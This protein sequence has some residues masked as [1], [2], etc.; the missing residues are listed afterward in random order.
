MTTPAAPWFAEP[1]IV[2]QLPPVLRLY[3]LYSR[4]AV[5]PSGRVP[6][7]SFLLRVLARGMRA[8]LLHDELALRLGPTTIHLDLT[9]PRF[10]PSMHEARGLEVDTRILPELLSRGDSFVDVG[11]NHGTFSLLAAPI[12]GPEGAI[13][14]IEAQP[15][16]A[17]LV[18]R[19]LRE[20]G[21]ARFQV[22]AVACSDRE[23]TTE[24]WTAPKSGSGAGSVFAAYHAGLRARAVS[25]RLARF[26]D[27]VDWRALPGKVVV[28]LDV[29]GSE[30][31]FLRG[32]RRMIAERRP[33]LLI[34]LNPTSAM[35]AGY[36]VADLL[37]EMKGLG[38]DRL[39]ELDS[40]PETIPILEAGTATQRNVVA[41]PERPT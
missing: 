13:V 28:K 31:G 16:L 25:V 26:D 34:E 18:E 35:A 30:L 15:R 4:L 3:A 6:G 29:E 8:G 11:A 12:I 7:G 27:V 36:A 24:L 21:V 39:A 20:S 22:L 33:P 37:A 9:D 17:A 38:Y 14:A 2:R 5:R 32:A 1:E 19:S 23:G 40:W 41:L 10:L